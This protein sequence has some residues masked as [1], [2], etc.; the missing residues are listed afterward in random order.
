MMTRRTTLACLGGALIMPMLACTAR[1]ADTAVDY[2]DQGVA[3]EWMRQWMNEAGKRSPTGEQVPVGPLFIGRF[4]DPVYYLREPIG[5]RPGRGEIGKHEA[6]E[7]PVGFVTDFAS[8]PREFYSL[9][10]P[11]GLYAYAAV[12][13]D[14]LYWDQSLERDACDE[15]LKLCMKDFRIDFATVT[16][17]YTGVHAGGWK[18]WA[19][20]AELKRRGEKRILKRFPMDPT[21]RWAQWKVQPG[22]YR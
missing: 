2:A 21:I 10:R 17:I 6:V 7:V 13:H 8:I 5:W 4:A 1:K 20:N 19:D 9:L 12:I 3:D 22:V 15:I 11:D 14:Y 16:T 18:A